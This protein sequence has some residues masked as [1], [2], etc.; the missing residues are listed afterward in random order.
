MVDS[1]RLVPVAHLDPAG[2]TILM[3]A[4][5]FGLVM[6]IYQCIQNRL[7]MGRYLYPGYPGHALLAA[8]A[9]MSLGCGTLRQPAWVLRLA[10]CVAGG[11][12]AALL[13]LRRPLL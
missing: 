11:W 5:T 10:C 12:S 8:M 2:V 6:L 3:V 9:M 1:A 13:C 7:A 4:A